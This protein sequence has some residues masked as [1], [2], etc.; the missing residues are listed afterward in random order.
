MLDGL[1]GRQREVARLLGHGFTN[2]AIGS[3]LG[4]TEN[5]V[6]VHVAAIFRALGVTNRTEAVLAM[7]RLTPS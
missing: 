1:T 5:T 6:K 3:M 2:K 7:Q 4:M